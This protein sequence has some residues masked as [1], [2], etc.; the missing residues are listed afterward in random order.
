MNQKVEIKNFK[1]FTKTTKIPLGK[2]TGLVGMNSVGKSSVI[3]MLLMVRQIYDNAYLYRDTKI[4]EFNIDLNGTY[5]LQLGEAQTVNSS[6]EGEDITVNIDAYRFVFQSSSK[7][8][9]QFT[10]KCSYSLQ[11]LINSRG[12]FAENFYYLN[13]ER[14]GPRTYQ[15]ICMKENMGCGIHGENTFHFIKQYENEKI[16]SERYFPLDEKKKVPTVNKQI[17]YWMD[18]VIPGIE[19]NVSEMTNLGISHLSIRQQMF[20]TGFMTPY[21]FGFGISYVLPIIATG[22]LAEKDSMFLVENPE[23]HLHPGGQSRIGFFLACMALAGVQIVVETHSEHVINGIRI[24]AMKYGLEPEGISIN[25]FTAD[26]LLGEHQVSRLELDEKMDI[27]EWPDGFLDQEEKDLRI[28][29][30]LRKN[31]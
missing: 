1:C 13:A 21:N 7:N 26:P 15:N 17:E 14:L 23:A 4:Q 19:L 27:M 12:I 5:G 20:D 25:F 31:R 6:V 8:L 3:Q 11:E 9:L 16:E 29:R 30:K 2:I 22:L 24:A 18:Y 28:L 10:V